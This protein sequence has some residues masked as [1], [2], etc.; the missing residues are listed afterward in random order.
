MSAYGLV[1]C[2]QPQPTIV[3]WGLSDLFELG[4]RSVPVVELLNELPIKA[5]TV[6]EE[7][8]V[9]FDKLASFNMPVCWVRTKLQPREQTRINAQ[10]RYPNLANL[11]PIGYIQ[12]AVRSPKACF[13]LTGACVEYVAQDKALTCRSVSEDMSFSLCM[14]GHRSLTLSMQRSLPV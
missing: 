8:Q 7:L 4:N 10:K 11:F 12:T 5:L 6:L 2:R 14:A 1:S 13:C 3:L 9:D